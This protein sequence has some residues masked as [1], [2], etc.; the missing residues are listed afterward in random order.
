MP[1]STLATVLLA[2]LPAVLLLPAGTDALVDPSRLGVHWRS[3]SSA[4]RSWR[5]CHRLSR[6]PA[7][8]P[9]C[10][11][12]HSPAWIDWASPPKRR[13]LDPLGGR[14]ATLRPAAPLLPG[15]GVGNRLTWESLGNWSDADDEALLELAWKRLT[16]YLYEHETLLRVEID[17]LEPSGIWLESG[18]LVQFSAARRFAG[19]P[20][21][22]AR[23]AAVLNH[24]NLVLLGAQRWGDVEVDLLPDITAAA[25]ARPRGGA[26][27][28]RGGDSP[29]RAREPRAPPRLLGRR[30][31]HRRRL[32]PP[33]GLG[34]AARDPRRG[35]PLG[36]ARRRPRRRAAGLQRPRSARRGPQREGRRLP[37]QR[38]RRA[39]GRH[40]GRRL[41]DAV[42]GPLERRLHRR[43][44]QLRG[45]RHR[46]DDPGRS[47]RENPGRLRRHLRE[48]ARATSTS[49]GPTATTT[50]TCRR[51]TPP[52][53]RPRAHRLLRAQSPAGAGR[54]SPARQR[55][56]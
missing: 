42:R 31:L 16:H 21:R 18:D 29:Q 7:C 26:R 48:R 27:A 1:R 51:G 53:T 37:L 28:S 41:P 22:G 39:A 32:S 47:V 43:R 2:V 38:R 9:S 40:D 49:K 11:P 3:D 55:A 10:V 5:L 20:V 54:E 52:A 12:K 4:C 36:G 8:P 15:T 23:L 35:R 45:R 17:E 34:L 46:H 56:G 6:R 44:R 19:L 50:A 25:R 24:G 13:L 33:P 14:W 30:L